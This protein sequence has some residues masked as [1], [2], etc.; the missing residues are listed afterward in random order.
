VAATDGAAG[1]GGSASARLVAG[2]AQTAKAA[3]KIAPKAR[4][5]LSCIKSIP[6]QNS[7]NAPTIPLFAREI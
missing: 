6:I 7:E 1:P 2:I 3:A 5:A 4:I